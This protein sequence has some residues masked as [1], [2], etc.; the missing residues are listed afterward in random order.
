MSFVMLQ[1]ELRRAQDAAAA[2]RAE[3]NLKTKIADAK[4]KYVQWSWNSYQ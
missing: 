3:A 2:S 4:R 1:V